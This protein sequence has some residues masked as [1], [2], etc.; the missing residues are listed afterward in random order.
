MHVIICLCVQEVGREGGSSGVPPPPP[1][2]LTS[3]I[4]ASYRVFKIPLVV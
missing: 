3:E 4:C 1:E 2:I